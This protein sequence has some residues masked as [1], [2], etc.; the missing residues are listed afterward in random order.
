MQTGRM[1][2]VDA[3]DFLNADPRPTFILETVTSASVTFAFCN[4]ALHEQQ[5]LLRDIASQ[6]TDSVRFREWL[7]DVV[8][9]SEHG[10]T[11]SFNGY[12]WTAFRVHGKTV[13]SAT[14]PQDL[15]IELQRKH[16]V[17]Y[18][19]IHDGLIGNGSPADKN[20]RSTH[21]SVFS[22]SLALSPQISQHLE[23][24]RQTDWSKTS[25]GPIDTWPAELHQVLNLLMLDPRPA[26]L[27]MGQQL[28]L[29]HI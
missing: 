16:S 10:S 7:T 1:D 17:I 2:R 12:I 14:V 9:S 24:V 26:T 28:S 15:L 8:C 23:L 22:S 3:V 29:I 4:T 27:F 18:P 5:W 19:S 20:K 13:I 21:D 6:D 25:I 11:W